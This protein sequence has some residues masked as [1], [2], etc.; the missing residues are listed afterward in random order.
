M[1]SGVVGQADKVGYIL[2]DIIAFHV[3]ILDLGSRSFC[4]LSVGVFCPE[5]FQEL[6]PGILVVWCQDIV[7]PCAHVIFP[8]AYFF[9]CDE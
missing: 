4:P 6:V 1:I 8:I 3:Q 7:G 9:S 5:L 2:V